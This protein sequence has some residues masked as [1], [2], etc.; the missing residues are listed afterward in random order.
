M[1]EPRQSGQLPFGGPEVMMRADRLLA[2][3]LLLQT[4]G[5]MTAVSLAREL[6][7][8]ERTI[9]R[10]INALSAS[11]VPIY[12]E[13]GR[14][15]GFSLLHS[16]RTTLTGL[17]EG[18]VRALFMMR[19][20]EALKELGVGQE[21]KTALLKLVAALPVAHR[22]DEERVRQRFYLDS[23]PWYVTETAVPHL[24]IIHQAV[25]QSQKLHLTY[26]LPFHAI[27]I[28]H[29]VE[30]YGLVAKT[31]TWYLVYH[32]DR[33]RVH[34]IADLLAAQAEEETFSRQPGFDLSGFWKDWCA[35]REAS[36][37]FYPVKV[38]AAPHFMPEIARHFGDEISEQEA[39]A[40]T[41]E[42][43]ILTLHFT[44][45]EAART[46][47]L[48]FGRAV[49]VLE[50]RALRASIADYAR[51]IAD[52]YNASLTDLDHLAGQ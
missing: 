33:F 42:A 41:N 40:T 1:V 47:L 46:R 43:V 52:L 10:D 6:E 35:R 9:Y 30:P 19:I 23:M 18:E 8:S 16:Y 21:L 13:P 25:W 12:G 2:L 27:T 48:A 20:P 17:N 7:V 44:S 36:R 51:Q 26:R 5:R 38:R 3:L 39:E 4:R 37:S 50:P 49:E 28:Q 32:R 15:G 14:D 24:H 45:L 29:Q 34:R 22:E 11:G 31:N